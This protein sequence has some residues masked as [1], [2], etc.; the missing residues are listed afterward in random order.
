MRTKVLLV[1]INYRGTSSELGGCIQDTQNVLKFLQ[2]NYRV[3][4]YRLMTDDSSGKLKPTRRNILR[5]LKWLVRGAT[6]G[7]RLL[8]HYSG[9]GSQLEDSAGSES[10][11]LDECLCPLDYERR[12]FI[13]DDELKRILVESLPAGVRLTCILDACHSGTGFDLQHRY[14]Q[15][16]SSRF[17][18]FGNLWWWKIFAG[19]RS[20]AL[21]KKKSSSKGVV[22]SISGARDDQTAADAYIGGQ[23]Q[24]AMTFSLLKTLK[25]N[26][27]ITYADLIQE[28][29]VLLERR[30]YTQRPQL[31]FEPQINVHARFE[32]L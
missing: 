28:M 2:S 4:K 30:G 5:G 18:L 7:D 11:G 8:F 23:T 13:K 19:K 3:D 16:S 12:G 22:I 20:S 17:R 15:P 14:Q 25:T 27:Q 31:C 1:G 6:D 9:H 32:L 29:N 21:V 24:G 10:D 26:N